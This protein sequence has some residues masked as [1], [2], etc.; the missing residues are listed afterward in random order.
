MN[1]PYLMAVIDVMWLASLFSPFPDGEGITAR[2]TSILGNMR[3]G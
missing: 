1:L 2:L 3:G